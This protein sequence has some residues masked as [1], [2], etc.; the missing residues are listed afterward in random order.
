M[1]DTVKIVM[2]EKFKYESPELLDIN[3]LG[4]V[5]GASCANFTTEG[6]SSGCSVD[7]ETPEYE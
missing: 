5:S 4:L 7:E 1:L 2:M 3:Y 6:D